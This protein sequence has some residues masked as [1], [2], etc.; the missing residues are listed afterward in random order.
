MQRNPYWPLNGPFLGA[1]IPSLRFFSLYES[2]CRL[3]VKFRG[4]DGGGLAV[5]RFPGSS[6]T[7]ANRSATQRT[8]RSNRRASSSTL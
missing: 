3:R 8:L 5:A 6:S 7:S 2:R 1:K 4:A